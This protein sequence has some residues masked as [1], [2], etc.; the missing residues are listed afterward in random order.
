MATLANFRPPYSIPNPPPD[1]IPE[2][3][4]Y[5][6][7]MDLSNNI[8]RGG[9][10]IGERVPLLSIQIAYSV[11]LSSIFHRIF[12]SFH[13]PLMV[14]QILSGAILS[15]SLMG[16]VPGIF[17]TL[18]RPEGILAVE[19]FANL[20]VMYYVFLNGLEMNCD[21]IIRSSKKA[22]TI[23]LV[24]ILIPMLGGAGFLALEHRV[25]GGSAK[26]TVSTKGYFFCCAILAVTG[27]PVVARLLSGLKI[28]YTRL[29][30]DALTAAML[31][32]AYGWIVFTILIPYSHDRGGKPLLSAICTFLFIVFCFYVVRPILTRIINRKI[33]LETWDSSGLLDVMVGLFICSSITDFLGA[34]HVV[35]AFVYGLILPSGKF[36]DLMMEILDD[37]VTALIVPIYFASFGFRLHLEALW[38]VHNSV[39]FPVLMVLLLTIPKVLGSML[40]TFYFGMSARDGLGLGLLL[41]TKGIMA[42]IMLSV[43]WDK[44]LLDPYAFTIMML[45]I[46]FMTVLVSP[47][48]NVIYKP[49]LRFMQ[50]QQ[51]T[52]QKLRN[53]AELRVAVC[54]HNAHQATG[55]IHVLEATNATRISP[56]Q[57]SVLHLV[58]LTRHG[59][60]LLVAQMDNPSSVQGE[61]HY[62][63]QEEFESISK[64]FEEFSEEYNAVRFETSSIVSTYESI[65]EDI[66]TVT[67]E[68]RANL[69][70]LP[71][72]KQLSSEGVLDTT[73]N[74]FSGINQ[75]VM[76]QPPCSVGIFVNR[77]L[78][79]LLKTKMSIIMIFIGGPDDREA[80]SI[81]WRMAGHSCTML[82]VVRLLLSGTEVA[83]EEKAFHSDSNGLLSTVMDSVMQK[84]LDDEQILHF[85]HKGVH[86]NDSISY[87]E[88][89][90]KI[91]TGEE[92]PLILNEIDKPGYDLYI[93]GQGSGKNY[94]ALQKLLEWCDNPELGAMGDIVASTSFG[95]SSSLLVVQQYSME[96]KPKGYR[97]KCSKRNDPAIL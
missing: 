8:W 91:E 74:A 38:A 67:Q 20:G 65:H 39:L 17:N 83:E 10:V 40:A 13:L 56:L 50:T 86:N 11:L 47:L 44:N 82:H 23:A 34:H 93:L 94:T 61:S 58:E 16:R 51:R 4:C 96:R 35:G 69:V 15:S 26:P 73:N 29:G 54:V 89:E 53:D 85:R 2:L 81:A 9:N 1:A 52:V 27:F 33:R 37:V 12:K 68:K 60:G 32:D 75:N 92:I 59:T 49:K 24:C 28:L 66:Y 14:S 41:N 30:K 46:L 97:K 79:S 90:V 55:M 42:V 36:A 25:S 72:H 62:G 21:T 84:E 87:S 45:A 6:S 76:Q 57:V 88:K 80:L 22:I 95:T 7:T 5:N 19:T 48:I 77:G 64:A 78:D 71:F 31:I 70:L 63:S 3:A 18:Y 43:A